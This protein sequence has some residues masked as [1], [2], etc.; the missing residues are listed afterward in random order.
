[1]HLTH[2]YRSIALWGIGT[3]LVVAIAPSPTSAHTGHPHGAAATEESTEEPSPT[4][5]NPPEPDSTATMDEHR[6]MDSDPTAAIATNALNS[7]PS[8]RLRSAPAGQ[9]PTGLGEGIFVG[10][11]LGQAGLLWFKR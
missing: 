5:N 11:I 9:M 1:M 10:M 6:A 8:Q 2:F 4:G 3:S 7:L